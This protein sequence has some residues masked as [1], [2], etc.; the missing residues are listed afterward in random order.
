MLHKLATTEKL[1]APANKAS[2]TET[3]PSAD[4]NLKAVSPIDMHP[5]TGFN[6]FTF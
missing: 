5:G 2:K 4:N 6:F 3:A 1:D